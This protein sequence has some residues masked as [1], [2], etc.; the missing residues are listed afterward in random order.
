VDERAYPARIANPALK[1]QATMQEPET[2]QETAAPVSRRAPRTNGNGP[3]QPAANGRARAAI[4]SEELFFNRELSWLDFNE[5][6]LAEALNPAHPLLER[7]KFLAIFSSNLDEFFMIHVAGMRDRPDEET[8]RP[9]TERAIAASLRAIQQKLE[10]MLATRSKCFR[11][12]I[13]QL[14]PYGIR[15][16]PYAELEDGQ[17]ERLRAYFEREIY[18]VLTPLAVDPGHPF[19]YISN[20]SLSLA[21]VVH[22]PLTRLDRFARVK[23]PQR[24]VLPRLVKVGTAWQYVLLEEV[25]RAHIGQLFTGMEIRACY[26]FR[27]TR[28]ADLELQEEA[29]ADLLE[30]IEEKL[31]QRRFGELVRLEIA[32]D[33]PEEMRRLIIEELE[34]SEEETYIVDGPLNLADFFP[35]ANLDIPELRDPPFVPAVPP[36]LRGSPDPFAAIRQGDILLHH[37]YQSFGCV[38]DFIRHAADDPQVLTIKH[39]LYRTS[40]DSPI[41][42]ALSDAADNGKQVACLVELKARFDEENNITWAKQLEKSGVHVVYGLLGLKTHC[43]VTLIVRREEDGLRRYIHVGTGNYNPKTAAIYTDVGILT[44]RPDFGADATDLFNFL[45]GYARQERYRQFL[46]APVTLRKRLQA[47][48]ERETALHTPDN[49]G[50]ILAKMNALVDPALIR[51]LYAASRKGVQ[52]DLIVR[53]MCCL[54]PG[55]K[56]L[57]E[58]IRVMS[59]VGRFLEH[60]RIFAFRNGGEEEIYI[61]SADWMPR[62]LDRRVEVVVP[63]LDAGIRNSLKDVLNLILQDNCQAWDLQPDGRYV[64]RQSAPGQPRR[65]SQMLLL[66]SLSA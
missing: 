23:V 28:N 49:P 27:V 9:P 6:V 66:E 65:N 2:T 31:T 52:I 1:E 62:N 26:P 58:N 25:I 15:L 53:G 42:E 32:R 60:S 48:V 12:L 14:A 11:E 54:R 17:Q 59:V 44:C 39:T 18:P 37:P 47:L 50:R 7:L 43:K 38:T 51:A 8:G 30:F 41:L 22:D 55:V 24:S 21:V 4:T 10:P 36:A 20:L 29:A 13:E 40:G 46:V 61:G 16:V 3:R 34:A 33:M 63:V 19:P 45:T 5:R 64:R 56:S 57:S 35:M